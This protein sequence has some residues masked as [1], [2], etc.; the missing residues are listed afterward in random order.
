MQI[1]QGPILDNIEYLAEWIATTRMILKCE[2]N[3]GP[4]PSASA[5]EVLLEGV[6]RMDD[7]YLCYGGIAFQK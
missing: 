1:H 3:W 2:G 4:S 5:G 6:V 7:R